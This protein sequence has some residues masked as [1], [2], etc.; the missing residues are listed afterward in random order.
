MRTSTRNLLVSC[1]KIHVDDTGDKNPLLSV[2]GGSSLK[3]KSNQKSHRQYRAVFNGVL[4][5]N[6]QLIRFWFYYVLRLA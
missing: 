4:N 5:I 2:V 3:V 1:L 6:G